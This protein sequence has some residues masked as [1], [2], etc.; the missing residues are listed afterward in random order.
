MV[1][2][3]RWYLA[4]RG[5]V[6][7]GLKEAVEITLG[8][9][10]PRLMEAARLLTLFR[11]KRGTFG[12][13][14][15]NLPGV[16]SRLAR[17]QLRSICKTAQARI[18]S[19]K[20]VP[21]YC[22]EGGDFDLRNRL[23]LLNEAVAGL[24]VS[25]RFDDDYAALM[26]LHACLLGTGHVKVYP[27]GGRVRIERVYPWEVFVDQLD[28]LYGE[29]RTLYQV[30]WLD[31]PVLSS[32]WGSSPRAKEAI[33]D[34]PT[35]RAEWAGWVRGLGEPVRVIEAWHL[36]DDDGKGGR[37]VI[38]LDNATLLDE[39]W[40]EPEFPI[41]TYRWSDAEDGYWPDGLGHELYG[42]Q[43]EIN[44]ITD[45]ITETIRRCA[46]PRVYVEHSAQVSAQQLDNQVGAIVRYRG[47][48]PQ[49][50]TAQGLTA[51]ARA[52]LADLVQSCYDDTG[53]SAYATTSTKP[54][55]L[56]SG[57]ALR[58]YADQQDGRLRDPG[59][60]WTAARV[61][62]GRAMVRAMRVIAA[63]NPKAEI[64]FT[65]PKGRSIRRITWSEVDVPDNRLE[66]ICQPV[67]SLPQ[68][69]GA[70]AALLDELYNGGAVTLDEYREGLDL[71]DVKALTDPS[72]APRRAIE[73]SLDVICKTA[74]YVSPEPFFP[75]EMAR[76]LAAQRYCQ[77][78][79][80]DASE[81][82]LALLRR[83]VED[84]SDLIAMAAAPPPGAAA[85]PAEAVPGEAPPTDLPPDGAAAPVEM[86]A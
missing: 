9:E 86:M 58:I 37:H 36:P 22:S 10:R 65:D 74:T 40:A 67:S 75:L 31:R 69:P 79:V 73:K 82:V 26:V 42:K 68:T 59:E 41:V 78:F 50:V 17:N 16:I 5:D 81:D 3:R 21:F 28:G 84:C 47:V 34:A 56:Q 49:T 19:L 57:R 1:K 55:G 44:R 24:F 15:L 38:A 6:Q 61:A 62:V 76:T 60:K 39:E 70:K 7:D 43:L 30:R 63:E 52:H 29:P 85:P 4:R 12:A 80:D 35:D 25:T 51:E 32:L 20:P 48:M 27:Q 64:L 53:I 18:L 54:A 23:E 71:P 33:R 13:M 45:A 83:Y 14:G 8:A 11:E 77:A 66:M 72:R 46:W 2:D